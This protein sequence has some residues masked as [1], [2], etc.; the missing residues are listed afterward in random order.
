MGKQEL[1]L[2]AAL[3]V[4]TEKGC[5]EASIEEIAERAGVAK[6]TV[7]LYFRSK[8]SLLTVLFRRGIERMGAAIKEKVDGEVSP[9]EQVKA[10]IREHATET[11]RHIGFAK[12]LMSQSDLA[13]FPK[14][15]R[16]ELLVSYLQYFAFVKE[17][18]KRGQ[19]E[20]VFTEFDPGI[21][22]R[23]IGGSINHA[24]FIIDELEPGP[25]LPTIID[26]LTKLILNGVVKSGG[27]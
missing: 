13:A 1:I 22:A 2:Q 12:V 20:G 11:Y 17:V 3:E 21:M 23:A 10:L 24:I 6:G 14:A 4:V 25:D 26:T 27:C 8:D 18:L 15:F 19:T 7:Y 9:V 5:H 16:E